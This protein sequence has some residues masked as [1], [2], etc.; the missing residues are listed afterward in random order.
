MGRALRCPHARRSGAARRRLRHV[1]HRRRRRPAG[2]SGPASAVRRDT[3]PAVGGVHGL[4]GARD[5]LPG[6]QGRDPRGPGPPRRLRAQPEAA[7]RRRIGPA[8]PG[9]TAGH[10]AHRGGAALEYL[11]RPL[12]D[13][14]VAATAAA[15][16][17]AQVDASRIAGVFLVGGS[18]RIPLAA[19]LLHRALGIAPTIIEQPELVVAGGSL[20]ASATT[21]DSAPPTTPRPVRC[22]RPLRFRRPF[23]CR[24]RL[25]CRRL[26][27]GPRLLWGL[28][29]LRCRRR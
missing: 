6:R 19:T 13:R 24:R 18:S 15:I 28:R 3:H 5:R 12:L 20:I 7:R 17:A 11:A 22:R 16:R 1:E 21:I 9:R 4:A 27:W 26:L 29:L 14:T 25:A 10:H 23:P 2:R 8:R